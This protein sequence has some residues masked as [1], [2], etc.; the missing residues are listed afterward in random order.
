[1]GFQRLLCFEIISLQNKNYYPV[2]LSGTAFYEK[3]N[4]KTEKV[5]CR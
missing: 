4:Q 1:M 3:Y 5:I 2:Y